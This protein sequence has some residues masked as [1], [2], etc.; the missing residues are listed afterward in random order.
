MNFRDVFLA[1]TMTV[2]LFVAGLIIP[3]LGQ[4]VALL[5]PVPLILVLVRN[6]A[7]RGFLAL[8]ASS[9]IIAFA[10][11]WQASMVFVLGFGMMG[12]GI[13]EGMRRQW[14]PES[15][16]LLGGML[17][18][19]GVTAVAIYFFLMISQNPVIAVEE[20]LKAS[21]AEASKMYVQLG[22]N[23]M[24]EAVSSLSDKF[25]HYLVRLLP[26]ITIATAISQ[27]AVCY[28]LSRCLIL[29]KSGPAVR[30]ADF[31][32]WHAPDVWVWGLI[33]ALG[34]SIAPNDSVQF[35]GWNLALIYAVIYLSQGIA[36]MDHYIRKAGIQPVLRSIIHTVILALPS[37]VLVIALG[38]VDIWADFRKVRGPEQAAHA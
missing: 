9:V 1:T 36:V 13:S 32:Q 11:G 27:A 30:S 16:V 38:I 37:I 5:T 25:I 15:A 23:E 34:L 29:K 6:G 2:G 19:L 28:G 17:P 21:V 20:Y 22:L 14:K 3:V 35:A 24:A 8:I 7:L 18:V 26:G 31:S 10:A 12:V 33:V 4:M